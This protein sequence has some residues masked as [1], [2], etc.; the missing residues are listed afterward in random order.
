[1]DKKDSGTF[2]WK[3]KGNNENEDTRRISIEFNLEPLGKTIVELSINP[4]ITNVNMAF[5]KTESGEMVRSELSK[6]SQR[7]EALG[8]EIGTISI[9]HKDDTV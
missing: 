8:L 7:V 4:E 1:M 6:F 9:A 5:S 3:G 2:L